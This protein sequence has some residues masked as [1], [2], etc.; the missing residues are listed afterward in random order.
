MVPLSF[1]QNRS[2]HGLCR[3]HNTAGFTLVEVLISTMILGM[4]IYLAMLSYSMFLDRW[5][6]KK[7]S[8]T[9]IINDYRAHILVRSAL[10]SMYDYYVTDPANERT[11]RHY[12]FFKGKRDSL[13][14]ITLSS[15]FKKGVPA[16]ARLR[17]EQ[18]GKTAGEDYQVIYEETPMD[19]T[20]IK[21]ADATPK[22]RRSL[23]VYSGVKKIAI[24]YY[25]ELEIK[26]IPEHENF[27][28]VYGWRENFSGKKRNTI[29]N[30]IELTLKTET[31]E[32]TILFPVRANNAFKRSFFTPA[33]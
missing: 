29:P 25:G 30:L 27:E 23:V 24:R 11:G 20:Y 4:V 1:W 32:T 22:Y 7:L 14:F 2:G 5:Q 26:W 15:V 19:K 21:Y 17:M 9:S 28:P 10:E 13:E 6:K 31:A 12:P 3:R 16:L 8:H 18:Q 33:L